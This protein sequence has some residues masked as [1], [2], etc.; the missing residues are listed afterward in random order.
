M[1]MPGTCIYT[2]IYIFIWWRFQIGQTRF[3]RSTQFEYIRGCIPYLSEADRPGF[4]GYPISWT[5][6]DTTPSIYPRRECKELP[7]WLSFDNQVNDSVYN[8]E[9]F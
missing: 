4:G 9:E 1:Y 3:H 7:G 8:K 6:P 5:T 2:L